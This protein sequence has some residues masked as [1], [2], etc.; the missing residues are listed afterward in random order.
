MSFL[1]AVHV[2]EGIVLASD[3]RTTYT[4]TE[5][6]ENIVTKY[7]GV[8]T[9]NSTDK[10]FMC[11]NGCG[12]STC[13]EGALLG[14]PITGYIQEMIRNKIDEN[15]DIEDIPNI[16]IQYFRNFE[17]V[18]DTNFIVAGYK[19]VADKKEQKIYKLNVKYGNI[20]KIDTS[21][22]GATWDGET[23]TLTRLIQDVA[24]RDNEGNYINL[25]YE[26]IMWGY[27]TLQDAIDFARYAVET[28]IQTM[29]FKKVVETVG[30]D[31]DILVIT[32]EKT[33]WLQK[34]EIK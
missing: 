28:T 1:I 17:N 4:S 15:C 5:T 24:M 14:T 21:T 33:K 12:I 34:A 11:P 27:F 30:G 26:E 10:T 20:E 9:T 6:R 8:H 18:P 31:V 23:S 22:Q 13:G 3:R 19:T 29:R 32:P 25:P 16:L 7:I 2:N